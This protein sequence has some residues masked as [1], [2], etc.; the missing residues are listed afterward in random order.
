MKNFSVIKK[1]VNLHLHPIMIVVYLFFSLFYLNCE[2]EDMFPFQERLQEQNPIT[3]VTQIV[4]NYFSEEKSLTYVEIE[5]DRDDVILKEIHTLKTTAVVYKKVIK[6]SYFRHQGYL[7]TAK[8]ATHFTEN[9]KY[10]LQDPTWNPFARFLIVIRSLKEDELKTIFDELLR[11]FVINVI[12]VNGTNDAEI[13][14]YNPYENYGCGKF[15]NNV[16][17]YGLCKRKQ[18]NLFPN[19]LVTGLR[20]CTIGATV[21]KRAPYGIHP[22]E[23]SIKMPGT[24]QYIFKILADTEGFNVNFTYDHDR[25]FFT[26]IGEKM[27]VVGPLDKLQKNVTD[28]MFG[29]TVLVSRRADVFTY[30]HGHLDYE[31]E[32]LFLVK[33]ASFTAVWK[34]A[35]LEFHPYVWSI[36]LVVFLL[37]ST[38][39]NI[40]LRA[41]DKSEIMLKLLNSLLLHGVRI[42]ERLTVKFFFIIWVWFA[43]LMNSIYQSSLVSLT[44]NPI[45]DH[46]VTTEKDLVRHKLKPCISPN[47]LIYIYSETNISANV[48]TECVDNLENV[49]LIAR[50][51]D[52]FTVV[53]QSLFRYYKKTYNDEFGRSPVFF[54]KRPYAKLIFSYFFRKGFPISDRMRRNAVRLRETGIVDK[55]L[56]DHYYARKIKHHFHNKGF[57]T[58]FFI[59]WRIYTIGCVMGTVVF[60]LELLCARYKKLYG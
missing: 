43:Y 47:L 35:Y 20:N 53:Q 59:P 39:M 6:Q 26:I 41:E 37:Y 57:E 58:R 10:L 33:R 2:S 7:L 8:T 22:S 46:Q 32:L 40:L 55:S 34:T 52:M 30:L 38:I 11:Y 1:Q 17:S 9:F 29:G 27:D 50:S 4:E 14:T 15:Y 28:V 48:N 18:G 51:E 60:I 21:V 24:E 49:K 36:L 25:R 45:M 16:I 3:C 31:D 23:S 54:F 42:P 5:S 12:V 44:S 56:K 19:K 13:Y